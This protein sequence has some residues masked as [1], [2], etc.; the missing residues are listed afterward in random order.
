MLCMV[1]ECISLLYTR[2]AMAASL[3]SHR[4]RVASLYCLLAVM[5]VDIHDSHGESTQVPGA[6][7]LNKCHVNWAINFYSTRCC[8]AD[9]VAFL[10]NF[11]SPK[12]ARHKTS[13][14]ERDHYHRVQFTSTWQHRLG[15]HYVNWAPLKYTVTVQFMFR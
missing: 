14:A 12:A 7:P 15:T 9:V 1:A 5:S 6:S 4:T 10:F 8:L 2:S 13:G 3:V 11:I